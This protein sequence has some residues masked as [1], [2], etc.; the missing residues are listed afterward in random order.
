MNE[1]MTVNSV[2]SLLPETK[3][4]ISTFVQRI[5]ESALNGYESPLFLYKQAKNME[6]IAKQLTASEKLKQAAINE[7]DKYHKDELKS[8]YNSKI[9]ICEIGTKWDYSKC[10]HEGYIK[11]CSEIEKLTEK[12][13]ELEKYLQTLPTDKTNVEVETGA[14]IFRAVKTS[15]TGIKITL[16]K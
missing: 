7:A 9:E 16:N 4:Q 1:Q 6:A 8:L 5:E 2:V 15:T 10:G 14:E 11:L 12:K 3:E 13:K